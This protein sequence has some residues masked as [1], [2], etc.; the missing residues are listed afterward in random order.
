MTELEK[1]ANK[2]T[3]IIFL[4][5][6]WLA[7]LRDELKENDCLSDLVAQL[8]EHAMGEN[9]LAFEEIKAIRDGNTQQHGETLRNN[10][11]PEERQSLAQSL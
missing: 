10:V 7:A 9:R 6:Q 4:N 2:A 1:L 11:P 8:V 5:Q 3:A